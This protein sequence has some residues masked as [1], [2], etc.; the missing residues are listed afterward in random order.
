[1]LMLVG[2]LVSCNAENNIDA[3]TDNNNSD[4]SNNIDA[5]TDTN[6]TSTIN[7][8]VDT[9]IQVEYDAEKEANDNEFPFDN[10]IVERNGYDIISAGKY[11]GNDFDNIKYYGSYYRIIDNYTDFSELTQWGNKADE[12]VFNANVVLVL[13]SYKN[14]Y[15][16]DSNKSQKGAFIELKKETNSK[17]ISLIEMWVRNSRAE[18]VNGEIV[19]P[20]LNNEDEILFPADVKETLYLLIPKDELPSNLP[21]NGEIELKSQIIEL[22]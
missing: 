5:S 14:Y 16:Y 17:K 19:V 20:S 21:I 12:S 6:N 10:I 22:E 1:M 8:T 15:V 18:I 7:N 11:Y 2:V 4:I 13:H 9:S 3:F